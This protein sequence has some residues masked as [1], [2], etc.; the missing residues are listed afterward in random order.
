MYVKFTPTKKHNARYHRFI[1]RRKKGQRMVEYAI[2]FALA[3]HFITHLIESR[4]AYRVM[5]ACSIAIDTLALAVV[6]HYCVVP[7]L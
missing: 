6:F 5:L 4:F 7:L 1:H 3:M 2:M